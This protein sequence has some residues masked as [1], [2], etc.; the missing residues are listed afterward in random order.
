MMESGIMMSAKKGSIFRDKALQKYRESR[1]KT[2]LPRFVAPPVF[3]FF[4]ILLIIFISAGLLV[5]LGQVPAYVT[6]LGVILDSHS[7]L[8]KDSKDAA[9]IIF[10]PYN[11]SVHLQVGEPVQMQLGSAGLQITSVITVVEPQIFSATEVR[12][13]YLLNLS[14]PALAAVVPLG[15]PQ[16][17]LFSAG[18]LL[19][20][21]IQVGSRPFISLFP[22]YN[23]LQNIFQWLRGYINAEV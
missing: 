20:A 7:P 3:I 5:W 6:G 19:S 4:W 9:A 22:V 11:S 1:E 16:T 21:Q 14:S 2:V 8:V 18:S 12:K 10:I 17:G 13:H 23:A 15:S